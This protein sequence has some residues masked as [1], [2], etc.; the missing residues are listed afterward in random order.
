MIFSA[1]QKKLDQLRPTNPHLSRQEQERTF[2]INIYTLL[3]VI[4]IIGFELL[5]FIAFPG[6]PLALVLINCILVLLVIFGLF[7]DPNSQKYFMVCMFC[8]MI[9]FGPLHVYFTGNCVWMSMILGAA[10]PIYTLFAFRTIKLSL[11]M[12]AVEALKCCIIYRNI[13]VTWIELSNTKEDI[14]DSVKKE[15]LFSLIGFPFVFIMMYCCYAGHNAG[16]EAAIKVTRELE[17][18]KRILQQKELLV[19][20]LSHEARNPLHSILGNLELAYEE[21]KDPIIKRKLRKAKISGDVLFYLINNFIDAGKIDAGNLEVC[22]TECNFMSFIQGMWMTFDELIR[23]KGLDSKLDV[24]KNIPT[25]VRIDQ[26]RVAQILYN[27]I[28]NSIKFTERGSITLKVTFEIKAKGNDDDSLPGIPEEEINELYLRPRTNRYYKSKF[29]DER[30]DTVQRVNTEEEFEMDPRGSFADGILRFDV[31]DTGIGISKQDQENLFEKW[32]LPAYNY[33]KAK[34]GAGLGLW[35]IK[36]SC[37]KL[38]ADIK[39]TSEQGQGSKFSLFINYQ[40]IHPPNPHEPNPFK[41]AGSKVDMPIMIVEDVPFNADIL[42]S[43]I[44]A[45]GLRATHFASNGLEAVKLYEESLRNRNPIKIITMDLEMPVMNGKEACKRIRVLED[46]YELEYRSKIIIVSGNSVEK[47][48]SECIN[49]KGY[50]KADY[51]LRK[52]VKKDELG[53]LLK[54]ITSKSN[55]VQFGII[56]FVDEV[57]ELIKHAIKELEVA[58]YR[59]LY[60]DNENQAMGMY[61]CHLAEIKTVVLNMDS[62]RYNSFALAENFYRRTKERNMRCPVMIGLQEKASKY[63]T[64]EIGALELKIEKREDFFGNILE[65]IRD[66]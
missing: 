23:S 47:E 57:P 42:A 36:E 5:N 10:F 30:V 52:P 17:S 55:S 39:V 16:L 59:V 58:G 13:I 12:L 34:L 26:K 22:I 32:N 46:Q 11:G 51:F 4:S 56:L 18:S 40:Q 41:L 31:I 33:H 44:Q 38:G 8:Y 9:I 45:C 65:Y 61:E 25:L 49:P 66:L 7:L 3:A 20:S 1:L 60:T 28:S 53:T 6:Y 50:I 19:L 62:R 48:V 64:K 15:T 63:L 54:L 2:N 21:T 43:Y 27:L 29:S 24:A 37:K 14:I 35:I